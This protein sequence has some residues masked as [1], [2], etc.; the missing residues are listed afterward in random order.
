M[1]KDRIAKHVEK[2]PWLYYPARLVLRCFC[3]SL[4]CKLRR[5]LKNEQSLRFVQVGAN[6][7]LMGDP[8]RQ[9]VLSHPEW[10]GIFVEP[11]R[12]YFRRLRQ[13]YRNEGRFVFE[14]VAIGSEDAALPFFHISPEF[15]ELGWRQGAAC[16][17]KNQ[18]IKLCGS[19]I[20]PYI[21]ESSVKV[22]TFDALCKKNDVERV[23]LLLMDTEG[24][25]YKILA[26]VN[27]ERYRPWII[28]LE[29]KHLQD[30]EFRAMLNLL[31][32]KGYSTTLHGEDLLAINPA[33]HRARPASLP[34][35]G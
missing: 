30:D 10:R 8:I 31:K 23:D 14:N 5:I 15:G 33:N 13:N 17:D 28:A 3:S 34:R 2:W 22:I 12:D 21:V 11:V 1:L 9:L 19:R 16:F 26:T 24:Y 32:R 27:F 25:E 18:L 7:G 35:R 20:E 6:D 4:A 29:H